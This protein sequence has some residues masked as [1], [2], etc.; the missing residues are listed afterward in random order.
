M[1][2]NRFEYVRSE[3]LAHALETLAQYGEE[4][5]PLAGGQSLIPLMKM[6]LASPTVVVDLNPIP[7]LAYILPRDGFLAIG[8]LTRHADVEHHQGVQSTMP[9]A[10]YA[11]RMVGDVQVRNLG[12]V[13]GAMA[14]ADPAG[15]WGPALLAL[16]GELE[17]VSTDGRRIIDATEFFRDFYTT[18]LGPSEL[19]AEVRLRLPPPGSGGAYLKLER[20]AGDFAVVS[21]AVQIT[22]DQAGICQEAGIGLSGVAPTP[23]KAAAAEA[24]LRGE[25]LTEAVVAEAARCIEQAIDPWTDARAPE[26]YKREMAGVFFRRA[27]ARAAQRCVL[28]AR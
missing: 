14:E 28:T 11:V 1:Y 6:R 24:C 7:D 8:A 20:R 27:L 17:C 12:T 13:A 2:P 16:G 4:A 18:A 26:E 23:V 15:D 10:A 19:V 5:R 3:S 21:A 22:L 25:R 9:L